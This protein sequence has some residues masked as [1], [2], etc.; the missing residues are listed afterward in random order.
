MGLNLAKIRNEDT[1]FGT[2]GVLF[3]LLA[4][5]GG[6]EFVAVRGGDRPYE[7]A[8]RTNRQLV[9]NEPVEFKNNW[10]KLKTA[11]KLPT[12]LEEVIEYT[13]FNTGKLEDV[14]M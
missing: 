8:G 13:Q 7:R 10:L 12:I 9:T 3:R 4:F 6:P 14:N 5:F 11:W 1:H 2:E